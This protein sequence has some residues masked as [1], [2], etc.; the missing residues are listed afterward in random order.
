MND[1]PW[2]ILYEGSSVDGRGH[3]NYFKRTLLV[4]EASEFLRLNE[5]D[6]YS[7][8]KVDVVTL[9]AHR[10]FY[11]ENDLITYLGLYNATL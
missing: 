2:F 6:P 11:R 3:P 4:D 9:T 10:S 5:K 7:I 8:S 1:E